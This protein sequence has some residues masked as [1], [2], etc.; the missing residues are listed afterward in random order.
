MDL[1][2]VISGD[3]LPT[4][5]GPPDPHGVDVLRGLDQVLVEVVD[6]HLERPCALT[7]KSEI[8][9]DPIPETAMGFADFSRTPSVFASTALMIAI[10]HP[11]PN[12]DSDG[13]TVFEV[14]AGKVKLENLHR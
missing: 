4:L 1:H 8:C 11:V 7:Y 14:R 6:L 9:L 3:D 10:M 13:A 5:L 12:D 2:T